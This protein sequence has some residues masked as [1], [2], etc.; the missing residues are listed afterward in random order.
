M[1]SLPIVSSTCVYTYA[2]VARDKETHPEAIF[3]LEYENL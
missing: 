2:I 1:A 3:Q